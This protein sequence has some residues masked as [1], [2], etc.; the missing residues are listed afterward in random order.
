MILKE[1]IV[2][3]NRV[4]LLIKKFLRHISESAHTINVK[5]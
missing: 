3:K 1:T 5:T 4:I 2:S